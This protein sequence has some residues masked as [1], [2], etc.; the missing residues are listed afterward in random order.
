MGGRGTQYPSCR[1]IQGPENGGWKGSRSGTPR[2]VKCWIC[3]S[4]PRCGS[5]P[6]CLIWIADQHPAIPGAKEAQATQSR[7]RAVQ[8]PA[9]LAWLEKAD[10]AP[11]GRREGS[12]TGAQPHLPAMPA[13]QNTK[14][15]PATRLRKE[16]GRAQQKGPSPEGAYRCH[17]A[18]S[19]LPPSHA[20]SCPAGSA[21][22]SA[23]GSGSLTAHPDP[24]AHLSRGQPPGSQAKVPAT[25]EGGEPTVARGLGVGSDCWKGILQNCS[26]TAP[27][28]GRGEEPIP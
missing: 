15:Q 24:T 2:S 12:P 27:P 5:G 19:S 1:R 7:P 23:G 28:E 11:G 18:L 9:L 4:H 10:V 21:C 13:A 20:A 26:Q 14:L 25:G 6:A 8:P 3:T 16:N 17:K 22:S